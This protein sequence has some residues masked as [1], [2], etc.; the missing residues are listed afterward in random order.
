M[1]VLR[2][3]RARTQ[4]DVEHYILSILGIE[5]CALELRITESRAVL[6]TVDNTR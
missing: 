3:K 1:S 2:R 5:E 6:P 4:A